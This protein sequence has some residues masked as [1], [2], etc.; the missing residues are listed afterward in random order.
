MGERLLDKIHKQTEIAA[1][2]PEQFHVAKTAERQRL[3]IL[4]TEQVTG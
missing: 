2:N 4:H 3:K 1:M